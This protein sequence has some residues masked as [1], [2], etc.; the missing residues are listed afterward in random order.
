M[1]FETISHNYCNYYNWRLV[2]FSNQILCLI[3]SAKYSLSISPISMKFLCPLQVL[4]HTK[5]NSN[6]CRVLDV[7]K[8]QAFITSIQYLYLNPVSGELVLPL[9]NISED[10][11][12]TI[13]RWR[14]PLQRDRL[15]V[16]VNDDWLARCFRRVWWE[17]FN[18]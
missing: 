2:L 9:H 1:L 17:C 5:Y 18:K 13:V 15:V 10:G 11:A 16:V 6:Q 4:I 7:K 3:M 12:A 8:L 14:L